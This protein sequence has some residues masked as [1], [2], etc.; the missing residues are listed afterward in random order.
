MIRNRKIGLPLATLLVA[1]NM[2]GSG[3]YLLPASLAAIGS[4]S[5]IAWLVALVGAL[6]IAAVLAYL[7]RIAPNA[8]GLCGY[9][10]EAFGPFAGFQSNVFYWLCAWIGNIAIG[11]A[12]IGYLAKLLPWLNDPAHLAIGVIALIWALTFLNI[13]A[14]ASHV[15]RNRSLSSSGWRLYC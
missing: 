13:L 9:A 15:R 2:I 14:R 5:V 3:V 10:T 1:G 11:V 8:R 4:I 12:A 7:S 6:M